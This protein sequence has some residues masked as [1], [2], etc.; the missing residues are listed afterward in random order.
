[1]PK[2]YQQLTYE[3]RYT[4]HALK[5]IGLSHRKIAQTLGVSSRTVDREILR[6]TQTQAYDPEIAQ[7]QAEKK[8]RKPKPHLKKI[9][10]MLQKWIDE[11]LTQHQW[12]PEQMAGRLKQNDGI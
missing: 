11:K 12:S 8:R 1:M 6:N 7:A 2:G 3:K 4:L 5:A 10:P 9:T